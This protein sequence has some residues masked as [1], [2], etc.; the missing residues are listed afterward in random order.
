ML[1]LLTAVVVA[2]AAPGAAAAPA[3]ASAPSA[4]SV[5]AAAGLVQLLG[6]REQLAAS[7]NQNVQMMRSGV[8]MRSM[9]AQQPGFVPAYNANKAKFD[10][11]LQKAGAIQAGIAE[12][13]IRDNSAAVL[14][15]AVQSYARNYT[16]AELQ[17]LTAF[18]RTPAGQ[19]LNRKQPRI[20]AEISQASARLI[21]QKLDA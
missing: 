12:K 9:L 19:A 14:N 8:A 5:Q 7:M 3:A 1:M 16:L 13:V 11:A 21:G 6:V 18:F 15:A 2:N 10:A 20:S 17:A 4:A